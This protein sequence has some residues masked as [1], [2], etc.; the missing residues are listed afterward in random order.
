MTNDGLP[1]YSNCTLSGLG[2]EAAVCLL[3]RATLPERICKHDASM[4]SAPDL[5]KSVEAVWTVIA[6]GKL[7]NF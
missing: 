4:K 2:I 3:C 7:V 1:I 5:S 6:L